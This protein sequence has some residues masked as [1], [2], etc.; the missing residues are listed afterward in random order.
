MSINGKTIARLQFDI[1][2][3]LVSMLLFKIGL[4]RARYFYLSSNTF[5]S[6]LEN[7][8]ESIETLIKVYKSIAYKNLIYDRNYNLVL[9]HEK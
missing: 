6:K 8:S 5:L 7:F 4:L 1:S 9:S 3:L 2:T